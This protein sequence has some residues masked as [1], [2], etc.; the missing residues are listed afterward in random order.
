[1]WGAH[2]TAATVSDR[3]GELRAAGVDEFVG[4]VFDSSAEGRV[5]TRALMR[6]HDDTDGS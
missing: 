1:V 6:E 4:I 2:P 3:I 5:R